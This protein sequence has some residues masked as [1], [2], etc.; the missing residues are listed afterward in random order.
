MGLLQRILIG[1]QKDEAIIKGLGGEHEGRL[2]AV[3]TL[4]Q[5]YEEKYKEVGA[6]RRVALDALYMLVGAGLKPAPA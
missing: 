1:S 6:T 4:K 3:A 5:R 2:A